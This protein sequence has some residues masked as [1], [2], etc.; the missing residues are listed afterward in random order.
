[1]ESQMRPLEELKPEIVRR[2]GRANPFEFAK[3]EDAEEVVANLTSTDDDH[4]AQVW[5]NI[6]ARYEAL[7]DKQEKNG[8]GACGDSFFQAYDYYRIARYPVAS[9]A[10]LIIARIN[11]GH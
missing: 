9:L 5:G 2:A 11:S 7:G 8:D 10:L 1:M 6:G 4:W 3:K